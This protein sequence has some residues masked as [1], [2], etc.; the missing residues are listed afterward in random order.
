M[1]LKEEGE[2]LRARLVED[3]SEYEEEGGEKYDGMMA[4]AVVTHTGYLSTGGLTG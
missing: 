3:M 1:E 4:K 2:E